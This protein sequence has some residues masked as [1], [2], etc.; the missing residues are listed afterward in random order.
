MN[1]A[2][3]DPDGSAGTHG[4]SGAELITYIPI[5]STTRV[6]GAYEADCD[7]G[8]LTPRLDQA[9]HTIWASVA[10]GFI[11][12]YASLFA[13]VRAASLAPNSSGA[14]NHRAGCAGTRSGNLA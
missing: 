12:L 11:L 10:I 9:R 4:Y 7:L 5:R 1:V 14:R 2:Y 13:I 3:P 6:I 8:A